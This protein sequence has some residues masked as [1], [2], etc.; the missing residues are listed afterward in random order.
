MWTGPIAVARAEAA[1]WDGR[2]RDARSVVADEL[3]AR[4]PADD[5]AG[6]YLA[7]LIAAGARAEAELAAR[8]RATGDRAG[9]NAATE[10]A[11]ALRDLGLEL[12]VNASSPEAVLHIELAA[13]EAERAAGDLQPAAW[14]ALVE[15]WDRHGGR[16]AAAYCRWRLA[17]LT[18]GA[19]GSRGDAPAILAAAHAAA[20]ALGAPPLRREIVDLARRARIPLAETPFG[21][22]G[23]GAAPAGATELG[24]DLTPTVAERVGL[25]PRELDVLRLLAGGATNREIA[26]QLFISQKTVTVHVTRILSKLDARSRVEAAGVAQRIGLLDPDPAS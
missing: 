5:E 26:G 21:A 12:T 3:A 8:G 17:E 11:V 18:L 10:R 23:G 1:L 19:R 20:A 14:A 24:E 13:A 15:R 4:D 7:P 9:E 6:H 25:T 16:F 22:Q 2:P